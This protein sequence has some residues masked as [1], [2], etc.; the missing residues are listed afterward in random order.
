M[1]ATI[2]LEE[3]VADSALM[4]RI[5]RKYLLDATELPEFEAR[6]G[7]GV[8]V[9]QINGLTWFSYRSRYFD[10]A[11]LDCYLDAGRRRRRRFKVRTR[12]Y[13]DSSQEWLEV[14]TRG[15]RGTTVKDRIE[16]RL[17]D[18]T[19]PG[20]DGPTPGELNWIT[21]TLHDRGIAKP[22]TRSLTPAL[23]TSYERRTLQVV[24][25]YGEAA[26]RLTID[27]GLRCELPAHPVDGPQ[28]TNFERYAF[29]ETKGG[30]RGSMADRLLWSMGHRPLSVSKYGLGIAALRPDMPPLKWRYLLSRRLA[31]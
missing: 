31:A 11:K 8:R 28:A 3:L 12:E 10:T 25:R 18:L 27:V 22:A 26:S 1:I 6:L 23:T 20:D 30:P 9:L 13:L 17:D 24:P 4:S 7:P 14:K 29:V 16:R 15:A 19:F 5:D 2:G 21:R